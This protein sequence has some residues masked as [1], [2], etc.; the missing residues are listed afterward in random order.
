MLGVTEKACPGRG[1]RMAAVYWQC[2]KAAT[3]QATTKSTAIYTPALWS[4]WTTQASYY[5]II[6]D[7]TPYKVVAN[8]CQPRCKKI[9]THNVQVI[10]SSLLQFMCSTCLVWP[11]RLTPHILARNIWIG[12]PI[13][14]EMFLPK[15]IRVVS[16]VHCSTRSKLSW[17]YYG[18]PLSKLSAVPISL[19]ACV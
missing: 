12:Q 3:T 5:K 15:S 14:S 17:M 4:S 7:T 16:V 2:T 9:I 10:D 13:F 6:T 11:F 8:L 18:E 19:C 1:P